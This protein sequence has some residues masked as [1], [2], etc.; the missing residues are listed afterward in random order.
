[1]PG[2]LMW[3]REKMG[4]KKP[5]KPKAYWSS[6]NNPSTGGPRKAELEEQ[7]PVSSAGLGTYTVSRN[8]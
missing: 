1:M 3:S 2:F 7:W 8:C 5:E 6:R 4:W